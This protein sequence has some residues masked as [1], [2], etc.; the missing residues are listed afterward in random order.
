MTMQMTNAAQEITR[1]RKFDQVRDG[2]AVIFLR[3]GFSGAS[4]DD[5]ARAARVSKA[6]LYSYFPDKTVMFR[7]VFRAAL[8][9]A[10]HQRPFD[11]QEPGPVAKSLPRLL[12]DLADW[13]LTPP[14]L[15]LLRT[16]TAEATRFPDVA[17]TLDA[18][19]TNHVVTPLAAMIDTWIDNGEINPQDSGQ[20]ARQLLALIAGQLQ[21]RVLLTGDATCEDTITQ[22]ADRAA[23]LF[24]GAHSPRIRQSGT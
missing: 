2:A 4:V 18:A 10:F 5:I 1:G 15:P 14:R 19:M 22:T 7:E 24:L 3:D 16:G 21:H 23:A 20:A 6:T 11:P 8:D 9:C 12:R 17:A 13:L